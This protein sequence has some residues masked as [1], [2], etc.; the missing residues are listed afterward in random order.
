MRPFKSTISL[1]EARRRLDAS[2]QPITRTERLDLADV[3]GRVAAAEITAAVKGQNVGRR[4]ADIAPGDIIVRPDEVLNPSR[5]GAVAAIGYANVEVYA[6][7]RVAILS[8]GNE[9]VDPGQPLAP[10]QIY[11]VNRFTIAALVE[12][13][14]AIAVAYRTASDTID[15]LSRAIDECL[16]DDVLVFS[17][18]SSVG[19]RDLILDALAAR[20]EVL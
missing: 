15:D 2:V 11:D 8:T 18:G 16:Q 12:R 7:P 6:R 4:G 13:H 3:A 9:V 17:G 20:G 10:G 1:D 14:G 5:L 19:E